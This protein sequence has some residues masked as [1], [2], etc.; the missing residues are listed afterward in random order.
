MFADDRS[1]AQYAPSGLFAGGGAV[2]G[3][4]YMEINCNNPLMSLQQ[5]TAMCG[6]AAN[7]SA[8]GRALV[9]YR[10]AAVP[11]S[12]SY[13]HTNYKINFGMRGDLGDGWAYDAYAQYGTAGY[14]DT[15]GGYASLAKI[16][17]GLAGRSGYRQVHFR[18]R[19]RPAEPVQGPQ[20]RHH[21]ERI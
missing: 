17:E 1:R 9:G 19:L 11:R 2:V 7:T 13:S 4:S 20:R 21:P 8:I 5:Q 6:A 3:Q 15:Q 12:D 10:F 16:Q 14:Q 18:R